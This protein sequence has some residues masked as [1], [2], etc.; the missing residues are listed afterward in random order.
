LWCR[1]K[2]ADALIPGLEIL[3]DSP[4]SDQERQGYSCGIM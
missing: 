1:K 2:T 3:D 4:R